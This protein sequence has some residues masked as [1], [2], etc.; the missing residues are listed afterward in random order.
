MKNSYA[1]R[2]WRPSLSLIVLAVFVTVLAIPLA[3][4]GVFRLFDNELVRRTEREL[5]AQSAVIASISALEIEARMSQGFPLGKEWEQLNN[6]S[7]NTSLDKLD[8]T[9]V[10]LLPP[11][12][13]SVV[14][15]ESMPPA[16]LNIGERLSNIAQLTSEKTLAGFRIVDATGRV[17]AGSG[18]IGHS[19]AHVDEVAEALEGRANSVVRAKTENKPVSLMSL[20]N[21]SADVRV[22]TAIPVVVDG[23]VAAVVYASRAP[24]S[25][26]KYLSKEWT[27]LLPAALTALLAA[28]VISFV[29]LRTVNGPM[30]MLLKRTRA[31][32]GGDRSALEALPRYGTRELAQLSEG[33]FTTAKRLF[34]RSDFIST[35]AAHASHE[36]K[37]PLTAIHGAAEL[38]RD[39]EETMPSQERRKFLNNII[40]DTERLTKTV[41]Q[42]RAFAR[43]DNPQLGSSTTFAT[44]ITK[45]R[46]TRPAIELEA[47]GDLN[48]A[49]AMSTDNAAI[50]L[51]HLAE[52]ASRHCATYLVVTAQTVGDT[53]TARIADNGTGVSDNIRGKIFE[54]FYT[55]ER[56]SGGTGMGLAIV[57][58]M[59]EAHGGS[60]DLAVSN[61][62]SEFVVQVP[63]AK[64]KR[65]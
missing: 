49:F 15:A 41:T 9:Q 1:L 26:A 7:Y 44:V 17:F 6:A 40:A 47:S 21:R 50:V 63:R 58:T 5:I 11:R 57:R 61:Q 24:Q 14:Q 29:F 59:L 54:P 53:L 39:S 22:F 28:G 43:A 16:V 30:H 60:I 62:G 27:A 46:E 38:M 51:S 3:V 34:D 12:P 13:E 10:R 23:H 65:T 20:V 35:F 36:L 45:L 48:V 31:L 42:L 8:L 25:L 4:N 18:E 55:T 64:P 37:S 2:K 32:R 52:N 33:I 19:L 56:H